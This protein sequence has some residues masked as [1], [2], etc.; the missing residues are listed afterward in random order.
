[1]SSS[2]IIVRKI[3]IQFLLYRCQVFLIHTESIKENLLIK[4][5]AIL[6]YFYI[7]HKITGEIH[8]VKFL[9]SWKSFFKSTYV[10]VKNS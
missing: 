8:N 5:I 4:R 2:D 7:L 10:F 3:C 1:M 9:K 6:F